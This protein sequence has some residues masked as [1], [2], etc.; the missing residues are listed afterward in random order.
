MIFP[1]TGGWFR[2]KP[3]LNANNAR[4]I[5][6]GG[7]ILFHMKP[8]AAERYGKLRSTGR[9]TIPQS[10]RHTALMF[11]IAIGFTATGI[12]L[13]APA[14]I[15]ADP[16]WRMFMDFNTWM[17]ILSIAFFG[18]LGTAA[19]IA[20]LRRRSLLTVTWAGIEESRMLGSERIGTANIAWDDVVAISGTHL[21]G[22]W[23]SKGQYLVLVT[24]TPD[25]CNRYR[26]G[27]SRWMR[28]LDA[29]NAALV[30][31]DTIVLQRYDGG[32]EAMEELLVRV[33]RDVT[34]SRDF[35]R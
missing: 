26:L 23:P 7:R 29:M 20:Q 11:L 25:A 6:V 10:L 27:L 4:N 30:G 16:W 17:G 33:H 19:L 5:P 31:P 32:P 9:V 34:A 3:R 12:F 8:I 1:V 2:V 18:V 24:L 14:A 13:I 21:G 35:F 15:A 22:R 28:R